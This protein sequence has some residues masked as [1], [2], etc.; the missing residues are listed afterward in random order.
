VRAWQEKQERQ[1][2]RRGRISVNH[3]A[4]GPHDDGGYCSA[5]TSRQTRSPTKPPEMASRAVRGVSA[6]EL[7]ELLRPL[8]SWRD[9]PARAD[10]NSA[11]SLLLGSLTGEGRHPAGAGR[12][13][14]PMSEPLPRLGHRRGRAAQAAASKRRARAVA[15]PPPP[16]SPDWLVAS[17]AHVR[18][19]ARRALQD[20]VGYSDHWRRS[21]G[22]GA[23]ASASLGPRAGCKEGVSQRRHRRVGC[24]GA[25]PRALGLVRLGEGLEGRAE[26]SEAR[27]EALQAGVARQRQQLSE[28]AVAHAERTH[29]LARLGTQFHSAIAHA[30]E[31]V[32]ECGGEGVNSGAKQMMVVRA[33][34]DDTTTRSSALRR[35]GGTL[36]LLSKRALSWEHA[37][38]M[39]RWRAIV[40]TQRGMPLCGK[41]GA[42]AGLRDQK[43]KS[44]ALQNTLATL[45]GEVQKTRRLLFKLHEAKAAATQEL[46]RGNALLLA[47]TTER[48]SVLKQLKNEARVSRQCLRAA[49]VLP[50]FGA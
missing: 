28:L 40:W 33:R 35:Y 13:P 42:R 45:G 7:E 2:R 38:S 47:D 9:Q 10:D 27:R 6:V 14:R 21:R 39:L 18:S 11:R 12:A 44:E 5:V 24:S 23:G 17:V 20:G 25:A 8:P 26:A 30:Q 29:R 46:Q 22:P 3:A 37:V 31:L 49:P 19:L 48:E 32:Q 36:E 15:P 34:L 1:R 4:A 16:P 43:S 50:S 41:T